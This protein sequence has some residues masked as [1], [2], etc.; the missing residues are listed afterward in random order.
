MIRA[1]DLNVWFVVGDESYYYDVWSPEDAFD[2][3]KDLV[4]NIPDNSEDYGLLICPEDDLDDQV[5]WSEWRN[6][7][8]LRMIDLVRLGEFW[9]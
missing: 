9:V 1:G 5:D 3:I 2:L 4:E 7:A 6:S 8:N